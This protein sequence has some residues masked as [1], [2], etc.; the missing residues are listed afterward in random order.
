LGSAD[1][2]FSASSVIA[3]DVTAQPTT[4]SLV[5]SSS[6]IVFGNP[7]SLT[8][9]VKGTG[10]LPPTGTVTFFYGSVSLGTA[11][12]SS[13]RVATLSVKSL[14]VGSHALK[15][16]YGGAANFSASSSPLASVAV[17]A[18]PTTTTLVASPTSTTNGAAITL[19]ATVKGTGTTAPAGSVTF[20]NGST[21]LGTAAVNSLGK[22]T[23][24]FKTLAVGAHTLTAKFTGTT[25]Y[26]SGTSAGVVVQLTK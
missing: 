12:V 5:A 24:L 22:A 8:A 18:Q 21:V 13:S 17:T 2:D 4:T 10:L 26:L 23:L 20:L 6:R 1:L 14:G 11:S 3:A 19:I 9:T 15:A 16:V 7:V 25:S